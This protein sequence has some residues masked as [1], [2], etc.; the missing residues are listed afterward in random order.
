MAR[1]LL[2]H[3]AMR[4]ML[5]LAAV[6][7]TGSVASAETYIGVAVGTAP[8]ISNDTIP[9]PR[10]DGRSGRFFLGEAFG[11]RFGTLAIEGEANRFDLVL[12]GFP[13]SSTMLGVDAKYS[14]PLSDGFSV[15]GKLGLQRTWLSEGGDGPNYDGAGNGWYLGLGAEYRIIPLLS[16]FV[17]YERQSAT[18]DAPTS[19]SYGQ[20]A[21]MFSL[22]AAF[23]L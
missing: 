10:N 4:S 18:I 12:N 7:A 1:P 14:F 15:F 21:G 20:A 3:R 6:L 5:I 19:T 11:L 23:H 22:G 16:V 2:D 17:D 13:S 8:S 9:N